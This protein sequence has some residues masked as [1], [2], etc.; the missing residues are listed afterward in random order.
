ME[1]HR[2]SLLMTGGAIALGAPWFGAN[3]QIAP[4]GGAPL[5]FAAFRNGDAFGHHHVRFSKD[6]ARLIVDIEIRFDVKFAFIPLYRYR[7]RNREIWQDGR[8]VRLSTETDDNGTPHSVIA[9]AVD[10]RL[11]VKSDGATLDLPGDT[12]PTS[13]WSEAIGRRGMWL[14]TQKGEVVRSTITKEPAEMIEAGGRMVSA[15]PYR[16]EG[17]ITCRLWYSDGY[18]AKLR[19]EGADGSLIDYTLQPPERGV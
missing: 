19:F 12:L 3:A 14:D 13:Y 16:L 17:D 4:E 7:H 6:G 18:W 11:Q 8:L 1:M 2:R 15:T 9:E 5:A 10:D